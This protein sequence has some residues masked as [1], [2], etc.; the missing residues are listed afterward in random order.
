MRRPFSMLLTLVAALVLAGCPQDRGTSRTGSSTP[1]TRGPTPSTAPPSQPGMPGQPNG[2]EPGALP[3][4]LPRAVLLGGTKLTSVDLESGSPTDIPNP[5]LENGLQ[6]VGLLDRSHGAMVLVRG[7]LPQ[8]AGA[9]YVLNDAEHLPR[10]IGTGVRAV[11]GGSLSE[12][13]VIGA[14][15]PEALSQLRRVDL[16]KEAPALEQQLV[17]GRALAGFGAGNLVVAPTERAGRIDLVDPQK[18]SVTR[19]LAAAGT[20]LGADGQ[21]AVVLEDTACPT[22]C[23]VLVAGPAGDR[24]WPLPAGL[25]PESGAAAVAS[26]AVLF[27]GRQAGGPRHLFVLDLTSGEVKDA[28]V[29]LPPEAGPPPM[30]VD[31]Q[32]GWAF[33]RVGASQLVGVRLATAEPITF[34]F[35]LEPWGAIAVTAGGACSCQGG[36]GGRPS[37]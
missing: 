18:G 30:A 35:E 16:A 15:G 24:T 17:P 21:R 28:Q 6:V 7:P 23:S 1:S 5:R 22:A 36:G 29:D 31:S 33:T 2:P 9:V 4:D 13:W 19:T 26:G 11:P 37:V 27:V 8:D 10:S 34:P 20:F 25:K 3:D 32:G 12:A 14:G